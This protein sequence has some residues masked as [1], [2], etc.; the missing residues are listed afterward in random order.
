MHY[1]CER[2]TCS[3]VGGHRFGNRNL[4]VVAMNMDGSSLDSKGHENRGSKDGREDSRRARG[5]SNKDVDGWVERNLRTREKGE[6]PEE[7]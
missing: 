4:V 5:D 2:A 3:V 1:I 6:R 7:R